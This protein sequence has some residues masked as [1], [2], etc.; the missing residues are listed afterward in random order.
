M[1]CTSKVHPS[2]PLQETEL[3]CMDYQNLNV[4][5]PVALGTK[6]QCAVIL[7]GITKI[8]KMLAR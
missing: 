5:I 2:A 8:D 1:I 3:L 6:T 7:V 4:Q